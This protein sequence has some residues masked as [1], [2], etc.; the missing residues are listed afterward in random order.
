MPFFPILSNLSSILKTQ[1]DKGGGYD[2][3][4]QA[5]WDWGQR[6]NPVTGEEQWHN[7]I[8]LPAPS[9]TPVFS[10]INGIVHVKH[11][12]T[13]NSVDDPSG[14]YLIIRNT[15]KE[16]PEIHEVAFCHLLSFGD[17]ISK[18][19]SVSKGQIIGYIGSTGRSTGPHLHFIVRTGP[20]EDVNPL[21]YLLKKNIM[22]SV[23]ILGGF[24]VGVGLVWWWLSKH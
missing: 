17:G 7:G 5:M 6:I 14:N 3:S 20:N 9:G 18:D 13:G 15:D 24:I 2:T 19:I 16:F 12:F 4:S 1:F 10:P 11:N 23:G 22:Q 21:D 8:D